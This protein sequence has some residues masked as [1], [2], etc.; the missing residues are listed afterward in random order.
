MNGHGLLFL[1]NTGNYMM[2]YTWTNPHKEKG[3]FY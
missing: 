3:D 1:G 2:D